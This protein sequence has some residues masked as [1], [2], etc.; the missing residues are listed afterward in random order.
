MERD[1]RRL[2]SLFL[3]LLGMALASA[4][5]AGSL[6]ATGEPGSAG[7]ALCELAPSS[8]P[9]AGIDSASLYDGRGALPLL[10]VAGTSSGASIVLAGQNPIAEPAPASG[11]LLGRAWSMDEHDDAAYASSH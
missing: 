5:H 4:S 6:C 8:A 1:H 2:L 11:L 9:P 10:G 3:S 7:S